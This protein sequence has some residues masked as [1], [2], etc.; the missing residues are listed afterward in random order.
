MLNDITKDSGS[1]I[2]SPTIHICGCCTPQPSVSGMHTRQEKEGRDQKKAQ[3]NVLAE[4][5]PFKSF[6]RIPHPRHQQ[7]PL[8]HHCLELGHITTLSCKRSLKIAP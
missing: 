3:S 6:L 5:V 8:M 7:P 2:L 4:S 1:F